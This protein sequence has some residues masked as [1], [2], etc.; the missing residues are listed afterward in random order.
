MIIDNWKS[1]Q[2]S[3]LKS[4]WTTSNR[5]IKTWA[6]QPNPLT[7]PHPV[8]KRPFQPFTP[9]PNLP[10]YT[11]KPNHKTKATIPPTIIPN[12]NTNSHNH[13]QISIQPIKTPPHPTQPHNRNHIFTFDS[14]NSNFY[15]GDVLFTGSPSQFQQ[16]QQLITHPANL[17]VTKEFARFPKA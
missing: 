14:Y 11:S 9:P 16:P 3:P 1:H 13:T 8:S 10:S 7:T 12:S 5:S 2:R 15:L 6:I 17:S 4:S